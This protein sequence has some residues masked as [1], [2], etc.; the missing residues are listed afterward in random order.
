M[1]IFGFISAHK[2]LL[3]VG[4]VCLLLV[5]VATLPLY[6]RTYYVTMLIRILMFLTLAV[7]WAMFSGTTGYMSLAPAAFFGLGAYAVALL[8]GRLPFAVIMVMGGLVAFVL[9]VVVGL[10]TLRLRGMYFAI[11]TFGLVVFLSEII[12]YLSNR[13]GHSRGWDIIPMER[14]TLL[15]IM[16]T[17][18]VV[19]VLVAY[20]IRRSRLG[21][22][23]LSIGGNEEAAEH[24]GI[25]TTMVKVLTFG[26][27]AFF[28]GAAGAATA[29][30]LVYFDNRIA[31]SL[32]YSFMPILMAVFGGTGQL[33]G[34]V[35]G[36]IVF[37]YLEKTLR[38]E[39]Q[40]YFML[41]FGILLAGVILFL[42]N[43]IAGVVPLLQ[44]RLGKLTSRLRKGGRAE[45]HANT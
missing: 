1:D 26:M 44:D 40:A 17:L 14:A 45:Q 42:P 28:M 5:F 2:R 13:L 27:S 12:L 9:A 10:I 32:S 4:L 37:G 19:T 11:F 16:L 20:F 38:T 39:L 35:I 34:P 24:M 3:W 41:G 43:G 31:F 6:A 29:P 36:A 18:A 8:Q 21:L 22:A 15:Y 33:Y 23:M 30:S 25:N 7:S